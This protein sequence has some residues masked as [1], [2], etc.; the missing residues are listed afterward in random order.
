M[1]VRIY[2]IKASSYICSV[3]A[4]SYIYSNVWVYVMTTQTGQKPQDTQLGVSKIYA[5]CQKIY[6]GT[7][8][9]GESSAGIMYVP[10]RIPP[11]C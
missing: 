8:G 2:S 6:H 3:K 9:L 5:F 4:S 7:S 11:K 1:D 10:L